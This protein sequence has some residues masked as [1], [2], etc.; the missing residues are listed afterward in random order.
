MARSRLD[1]TL[2]E[3]GLYPSRAKAQA[4]V[5][6]GHVRVD[7]SVA[8]KAGLA[9]LDTA[10]IET[11]TQEEFVSRGGQKLDR[12]LS[13]LGL[14]VTGADALDVGASTGGFTDCLLRRGA[15]RV[16]A[17]DVGYGQLA[18]ALRTDERVHV[19]ERHNARKLTAEELPYSPNLVTVDVSFI[20][21]RVVWP[22]VRACLAPDWHALIMVKPQFELEPESVGSGG[23]VRD[24]A[25]R[26]EAVRRVIDVVAEH[27]GGV[28]GVA[29]SGLPGPKG[30]R[31]IFIQATSGPGA[32][33][34]SVSEALEAAIRE[35]AAA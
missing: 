32:D 16:I 31:E 7:G 23:V 12:A 17:L 19:L 24:P 25:L 34:G 21:A 8:Q 30:N 15:A 22:A 13:V 18:W 20:G 29:D 6:A 27:G 35:G 28:R 5:M 11:D 14:D 33:S 10:L 3:R 4:A 2:V 26:A 1:I 9:V